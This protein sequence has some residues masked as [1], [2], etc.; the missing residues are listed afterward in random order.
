MKRFISLLLAVVLVLGLLTVAASAATPETV[1]HYDTYTCLGDSIAA[2][3]GLKTYPI[4][5]PDILDGTRV[6]GSYADL[7]G[8]AVDCKTYYNSAHCG[9]RA[10][11]ID[12]LLDLDATGDDLTI[13]ML[14]S[15]MNLD[16]ASSEEAIATSMA[17][18][19]Q[20]RLD[21]IKS[22]EEADL[23]TLNVGNNDTLTY[24]LLMW[25]V[26]ETQRTA[27]E[28]VLSAERTVTPVTT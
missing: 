9:N 7:L 4:P 3:Y 17:A 20:L 8:K 12:W 28:S 6:E 23:I 1:Q 11:D 25:S 19:Q 24:A 5:E 21:T 22:V 2:G 14:A 26:E 18:L 27:N 13:P 10:I 15:A 16:I